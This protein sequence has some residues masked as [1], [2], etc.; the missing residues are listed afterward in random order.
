MQDNHV[1]E[2]HGA[3]HVESPDIEKTTAF[4]AGGPFDNGEIQWTAKTVVATASLCGIWT[5][6]ADTLRETC[7]HADL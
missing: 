4:D 2:K 6:R 7:P 3:Q 1:D 5:G